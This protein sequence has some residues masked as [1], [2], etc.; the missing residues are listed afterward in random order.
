M[1]GNIAEAAEL[2]DVR[3]VGGVVVQFAT[4]QLA[5]RIGEHA[6]LG[7]I[8]TLKLDYQRYLYDPINKRFAKDPENKSD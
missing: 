4:N 8:Q 5:I 7:N 2:L 1:E 6:H 3:V